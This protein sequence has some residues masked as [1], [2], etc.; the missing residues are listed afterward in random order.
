MIF[1]H[2]DIE[3]LFISRTDV[4]NPLASYSKHEF[5]L[6]DAEWP[7]VEHYYQAM[8][9]EDPAYREQIRQAAH[10]ADAHT[11]GK[12]KKFGRRKD[13]DKVKEVYMTRGVYVKCRTHPEVAKA[14]L[15]SGDIPIVESSQYDYYWGC[16]RDMRGKNAYGKILMN[17]RSKLREEESQK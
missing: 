7:S 10:P 15:D 9:F 12:S 3:R 1:D 2:R 17:V 4:T 14:L 16:G 6:D 8:K 11:L 13:W 5:T